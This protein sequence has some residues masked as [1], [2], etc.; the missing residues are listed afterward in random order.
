MV[1]RI[2]IDIGGAFTDLVGYD[3]ETGEFVWVKD[4]TTVA[5]PS[6]GVLNTISKSGIDFSKVLSI[7]HGQTL[8]INTIIERKGAKVGLITT[9]GYRD[10]LELQ[11]SNRRDMYNFRYQKP[12]PIVPRY[13]RLEVDERVLTDGSVLKP[14]CE[15]SV[16]EA[17]KKLEKEGVESI[18]ISFINSYANPSHELRACEIVESQTRIPVTVGHEITREWREYE[19]TMTAVLSAYVKPKLT[20]YLA[21]LEEA[22]KGRGFRRHPFVMLSNGGVATFEVAKKFPIYTIESGPVAGVI[23]GV[24]IARLVG[25]DNVIVLD[26]GSTTTKASLVE[27]LTPR[28]HTEYY[29]ERTK[30]TAGY[31]VRVPVV[32]TFEIGNGGT[33]I[34]WIDAIGNLRVGPKAAGAYPGPACYGKGG[35]EPTVTDAYVVNGLINPEYLLGGAMKIHKQLAYNAIKQKVADHYNISVHEA[36][37]GIIKLANENA[38]F[39]I[40]VVSVQRGYDPRDFTLIVHGGSGPMFAPFIAQELEIK[41]IIVPV[42][43]PGVFSAWGMLTTDMRHDIVYT[44]I[45]RLDKE[46]N[47]K[48]INEIYGELENK[49]LNIFKEE[50]GVGEVVIYRFADLRYYGQEHTVKVP[51]PSSSI[52]PDEL[53]LLAERFHEYHER[54]Y[55]F[56]LD[57]PIEIVNFHV[58]GEFKIKK[59]ELK[60][61]EQLANSPDDALIGERKIHLNGDELT[62]PVY[63][64]Q[65]LS[66]GFHIDGPAIIE[67]PTSTILVLSLQKVAVD[68]YGNVTISER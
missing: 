66:P 20:K 38:A 60:E 36:A 67:D 61:I 17:L 44:E 62:L 63:D 51:V 19:R 23:G 13:L 39:A 65:K 45:I 41:K 47:M 22:F 3:D 50:L 9:R 49:I 5:D 57:G 53:K 15:E 42:I 18:C 24:Y 33:S 30:F 56:R 29:V 28:V 55:A 43:P 11:R 68:K 10:V 54:E 35:T 4:E 59:F 40:R 6:I 48:R 64:K 34:S 21:R 26:G 25:E 31:P 7:I 37:E 1:F 14:L 16:K 12:D 58:V 46:S 52:G 8:V 32:D 2:G 27:N